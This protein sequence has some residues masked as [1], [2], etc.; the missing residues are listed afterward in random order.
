MF[1][2]CELKLLR[3]MDR[4]EKEKKKKKDG[5]LVKLKISSYLK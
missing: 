3:W 5:C 1:D 2:H 4:E